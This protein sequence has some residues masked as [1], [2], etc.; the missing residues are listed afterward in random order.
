[1][2]VGPGYDQKVKGARNLLCQR[3][4]LGP[5]RMPGLEVLVDM[6]GVKYGTIGHQ[7]IIPELG[8]LTMQTNR[9]DV[10]EQ[11]ANADL[12]EQQFQGMNIPD[13]EARDKEVREKE[14][15]DKEA[16]DLGKDG[17]VIE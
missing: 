17:W 5:Y 7:Y 1:M 8:N 6:G 4:T 3:E 16:R 15:R 12:L 11:Q 9:A 13:Q 14:A 10:L 2:Y